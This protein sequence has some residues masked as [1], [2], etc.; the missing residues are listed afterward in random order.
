MYQEFVPS[1]YT[2]FDLLYQD[3]CQWL[4]IAN[5]VG[6]TGSFD[7]QYTVLV[8]VFCGGEIFT[9]N[10]LSPSITPC[11]CLYTEMRLSTNA[12][13]LIINYGSTDIFYRNIKIITA[14]FKVQVF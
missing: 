13:A 11:A 14:M 8:H 7:F 5:A 9:V 4:Q 12:P 3:N 2:P 1:C 6:K 10:K